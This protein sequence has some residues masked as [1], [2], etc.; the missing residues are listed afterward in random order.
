MRSILFFV[1]L[2]SPIFVFSQF[3]VT[4][5]RLTD[6]TKNIFYIGADNPIR[7]ST[8][9]NFS[10]YQITMEGAGSS[11]FK[12]GLNEYIVGVSTPGTCSL[13]I[14]QNGK[15]VFYKEFKVDTLP[16]PVATLSGMHDTTVSKNRILA[17]PFISVIIP[18][19]LY[20][21]GFYVIS[22]QAIFIDGNDSTYTIARSNYLSE[23]QIR[24]V[25]SE[26]QFNKIYFNGI[27]ALCPECR[28]QALPP[29][30]IKIE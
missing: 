24:L 15:Q 30:W 19:C 2:F 23:E 7:V 27:R 22:F 29:F 18:N 21:H 17:N 20:Q 3:N 6:S 9:K 26:N 4:C 14:K 12:T 8:T 11:L 16:K 1:S 5:L 28:T 10:N 25:K 13:K